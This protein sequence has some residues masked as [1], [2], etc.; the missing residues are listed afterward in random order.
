M[1]IVCFS[2]VYFCVLFSCVFACF[3]ESVFAEH[4]LEVVRVMSVRL[5]CSGKISQLGSPLRLFTRLHELDR[6]CILVYLDVVFSSFL[7]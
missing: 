4:F 1:Y 5:I 6:I 3:V 7:R 2:H